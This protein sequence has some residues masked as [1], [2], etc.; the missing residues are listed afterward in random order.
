MRAQEK[1]KQNLS[2]RDENSASLNVT[3]QEEKTSELI[4]FS[5]FFQHTKHFLF[6]LRNLF[7]FFFRIKIIFIEKNKTHKVNERHDFASW[8]WAWNRKRLFLGFSLFFF[9]FV[10]PF[11]SDIISR[12]RR[13]MYNLRQII[14]RA[15]LF[16]ASQVSLNIVALIHIWQ[17]A[18]YNKIVPHISCV[19]ALGRFARSLFVDCWRNVAQLTHCG[20]CECIAKKVWKV[21]FSKQHDDKDARDTALAI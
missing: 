13:L 20:V 5:V 8:F 4:S 21:F 16:Y 1:L 12:R 14:F 17:P 3:K 15:A 11:L 19:N 9:F 2:F 6:N 10:N 7:H 18:K